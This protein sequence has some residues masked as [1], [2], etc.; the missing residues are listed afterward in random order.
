[1]LLVKIQ[2]LQY[3]VTIIHI[4]HTSSLLTLQILSFYTYRVDNL[5]YY[6]CQSNLQLTYFLTGWRDFGEGELSSQLQ[7]EDNF[8]MFGSTKI[9]ECHEIIGKVLK[10]LHNP[11]LDLPRFQSSTP[12]NLRCSIYPWIA[13][14]ESSDYLMTKS[15]LNVKQ[16]QD[17]KDSL[18]PTFNIA[19][20]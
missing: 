5:N 10:K 9:F 15:Q 19:K 14:S 2:H 1:M 8:Y 13:C 3:L 7:G 18:S 6:K 12:D 17:L 4:I 20:V 16:S 11:T